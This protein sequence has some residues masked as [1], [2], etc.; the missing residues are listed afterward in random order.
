MPHTPLNKGN[1]CVSLYIPLVAINSWT[2]SQCSSVVFVHGMCIA[3]ARAKSHCIGKCLVRNLSLRLVL[4]CTGVG[5]LS[6]LCC[7]A[8]G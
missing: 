8:Q 4:V 3:R 5:N 7:C 2:T 1:F 6:F